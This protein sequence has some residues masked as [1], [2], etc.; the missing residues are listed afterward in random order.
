V[1]SKNLGSR[2]LSLAGKRLAADWQERYQYRPVLLETFVEMQRFRGTCYKAANWQLC[3]AA[4][5]CHY[6]TSA[7]M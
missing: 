1:R 7:V 3:A 5:N 4:H 2:I 6:V